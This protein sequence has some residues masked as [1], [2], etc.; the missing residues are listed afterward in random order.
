MVYPANEMLRLS[1]SL[2]CCSSSTSAFIKER[3]SAMGHLLTYKSYH[4]YGTESSPLQ[5]YDV[6]AAAGVYLCDAV[7]EC[8]KINGD[9][10]AVGIPSGFAY[11]R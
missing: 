10:V 5:L 7:A 3:I 9:V 4:L 8:A 1:H 2:S 11:D 6:Y